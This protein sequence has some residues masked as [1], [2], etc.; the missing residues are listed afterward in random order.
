MADRVSPNRDSGELHDQ[1]R[2]DD[3]GRIAVVDRMHDQL[4]QP[5]LNGVE[6]L[7]FTD[8]A[9]KSF[10]GYIALQLHSGGLGDMRFKDIYVRDLSVR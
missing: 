2:R 1:R 6:V 7:N 8:P 3:A 5:V 4:H 9:P 10:D